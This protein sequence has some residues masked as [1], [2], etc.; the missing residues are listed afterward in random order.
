M[1]PIQNLGQ[2]IRNRTSHTKERASH[3]IDSRKQLKILF[4]N[5]LYLQGNQRKHRLNETGI[6]KA[7]ERDEKLVSQRY[8][9]KQESKDT[10]NLKTFQVSRHGVY[11]WKTKPNKSVNQILA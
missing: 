7:T 6:D 5:K 8:D 10:N 2:S 11:I 1:A 3:K 4:L 9:N